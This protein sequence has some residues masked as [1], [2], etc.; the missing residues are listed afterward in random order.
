MPL[1]NSYTGNAS[2]GPLP[3]GYGCREPK[4]NLDFVPWGNGRELDTLHGYSPTVTYKHRFFK[5]G[6][7]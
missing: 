4:G 5:H 1:R 7:E 2:T 3:Y 6:V